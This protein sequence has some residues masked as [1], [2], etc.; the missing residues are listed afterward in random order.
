MSDFYSGT[1]LAFLGI[2]A[3]V[4]G[5]LLKQLWVTKP[6]F[7]EMHETI[8]KQI[9]RATAEDLLSDQMM[10]E[11]IKVELKNLNK[12][13]DEDHALLLEIYRMM[14]GGQR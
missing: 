9:Q 3:T 12:T 7:Q 6:N 13:R 1:V 5:W 14:G 10:L 4:Q 11:G 2:L 8:E